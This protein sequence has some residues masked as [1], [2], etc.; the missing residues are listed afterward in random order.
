MTDTVIAA[1]DALDAF[2]TVNGFG[3]ATTTAGHCWIS[4]PTGRP[5]V[6]WDAYAGTVSVVTPDLAT[7]RFHTDDL[8]LVARVRDALTADG[9]ATHTPKG[10][11]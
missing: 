2:L 11:R 1:H 4:S 7:T 5:S 3:R 10:T 6:H 9:H 8:R